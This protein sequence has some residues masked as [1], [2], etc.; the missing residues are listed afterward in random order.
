MPARARCR[1]SAASV[2]DPTGVLYAYTSALARAHATRSAASVLKKQGHL[3]VTISVRFT[4]ARSLRTYVDDLLS[5]D[6]DRGAA[7]LDQG[8]LG[9]CSEYDWLK[10][11]RLTDVYLFAPRHNSESEYPSPTGDP[12]V[13]AGR[14][15]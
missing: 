11:S 12:S 1:S 13:A 8:Q 10:R 7:L 4:P 14:G 5:G 2:A 15:V 3:R 6:R 9:G